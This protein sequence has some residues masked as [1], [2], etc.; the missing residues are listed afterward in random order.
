[1][2]RL[3]VYQTPSKL[4]LVGCAED[5]KTWRILKVDRLEPRTLNVDDDGG[6][7]YTKEEANAVLS[8]VRTGLCSGAPALACHAARRLPWRLS[9]IPM[10]SSAHVGLSRSEFAG[11]RRAHPARRPPVGLQGI[12][13][14]G[15]DQLPSGLLPF[16]RD[17]EEATCCAAGAAGPRI[18]DEV[19][20][21]YCT[22]LDAHGRPLPWNFSAVSD[23]Y[24]DIVTPVL[25]M[26]LPGQTV[27]DLRCLTSR[28]PI[29][30]RDT[31]STRCRAPNASPSR[32][33]VSR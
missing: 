4:Y 31:R 14:S 24:V 20:V 30:R 15:R 10:R 17:K 22:H 27:R 28:R 8:L 3:F 32:T 13:D 18:G 12:Y 2:S 9:M 33:Q 21:T 5:K 19:V 25:P 11:A 23:R 7:T 1:M 16:G 29:P 26:K 6:V